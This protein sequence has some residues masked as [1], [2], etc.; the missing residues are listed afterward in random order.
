MVEFTANQTG[1]YRVY[2][3]TYLLE[4]ATLGGI[5]LARTVELRCHAM[6]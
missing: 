6:Q 3:R 5:C 1:T 2:L 4:P